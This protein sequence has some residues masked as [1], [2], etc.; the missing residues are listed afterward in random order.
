VNRCLRPAACILA[1]LGLLAVAQTPSP[2]GTPTAPKNPAFVLPY[3]KGDRT[4]ARISGEEPPRPVTAGILEVVEIKGFKIETF[5]P[6]G[7]PH[8]V[9]EAPTCV[10]NLASQNIWSSGPLTIT[11]IG[12]GFSLRGEGFSWNRET[13]RLVLSNKVHGRLRIGTARNPFTP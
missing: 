4:V 10:L 7:T 13:E 5:N 6:D 12:G 3:K 2:G 1:G 8:L 9:G 11:Q